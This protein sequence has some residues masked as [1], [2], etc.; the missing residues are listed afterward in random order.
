MFL[1]ASRPILNLWDSLTE[2][3]T[4]FERRNKNSK[5]L[6]KRGQYYNI[7][8]NLTSTAPGLLRIIGSECRDFLMA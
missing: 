1:T 4:R 5:L 2:I 3:W 7:W 6:C 8:L